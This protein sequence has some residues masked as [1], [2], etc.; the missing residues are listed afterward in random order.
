MVEV[1]LRRVQLCES[2]QA[3]VI[4]VPIFIR[5]VE[6][7]T[8]VQWALES[9]RIVELALVFVYIHGVEVKVCNVECCVLGDLDFLF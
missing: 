5:K 8:S 6:S 7:L 4:L 3:L 9:A 2:S 1:H